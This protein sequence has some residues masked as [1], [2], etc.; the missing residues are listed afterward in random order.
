LNEIVVNVVAGMMPLARENEKGKRSQGVRNCFIRFT[1]IDFTFLPWPLLTSLF[2]MGLCGHNKAL[3][4]TV[5][6]RRNN[7]LF[8]EAEYPQMI[9]HL[10]AKELAL[11]HAVA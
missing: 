7:A 2:S 1:D 9:F 3:P 5:T 6:H 4:P 11:K 10:V 8:S